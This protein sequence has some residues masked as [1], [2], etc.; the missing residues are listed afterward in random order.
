MKL[1]EG[2]AVV[3]FI[4]AA[5]LFSSC[6]S[7][8]PPAG[9]NLMVLG[10]PKVDI[11]K[12]YMTNPDSEINK[13]DK[14]VILC[15]SSDKRCEDLSMETM[16]NLKNFFMAATDT[17]RIKDCEENTD[18]NHPK[19]L[20]KILECGTEDSY[21]QSGYQKRVVWAKFIF[22]LKFA[23]NDI[24]SI[25]DEAGTYE[26]I[27]HLCDL[28]VSLSGIPKMR[29]KLAK[30]IAKKFVKQVVPV[31]KREFREF[32]TSQSD[33]KDGVINAEN[34]NWDRAIQNWEGL[35]SKDEKNAAA[36]YNLGI[37]YEVQKK[38][39]KAEKA[40]GKALDLDPGNQLYNRS[41]GNFNR[42]K[43]VH[44]SLKKSKD[45]IEEDDDSDVKPLFLQ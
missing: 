30:K 1:K 39:K 13:I 4:L 2:L 43:E 8:S 29:S 34:N 24:K 19:L 32:D 15:G 35:V 23:N 6:I 44:D 12:L 21:P 36:Y 28:S 14:Q 41:K 33:V 37:A 45:D 16:S 18:D 11:T 25:G 26:E 5:F 20:L 17:F 38:Y 10:E 9:V 3:W 22:D 40:Y 31:K 7:A 27:S 42:N